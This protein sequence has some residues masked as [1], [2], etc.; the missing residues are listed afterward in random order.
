MN[1]YILLF[2]VSQI[3]VSTYANIFNKIK[4]LVNSK[5]PATEEILAQVNVHLDGIN[6]QIKILSE[7]TSN[8]II[9][10]VK[11]NPLK[12]YLHILPDDIETLNLFTLICAAY[13]YKYKPRVF[14]NRISEPK[15]EFNYRPEMKIGAWDIIKPVLSNRNT[16]AIPVVV[17]LLYI[18]R[19]NFKDY[20]PAYKRYK[21][22]QAIMNH[23]DSIHAIV[24]GKDTAIFNSIINIE[25][26]NNFCA[27]KEISTEMVYLK[28]T[29]SLISKTCSNK[30]FWYSQLI[31]VLKTY[32]AFEKVKEEFDICLKTISHNKCFIN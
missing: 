29:N 16:G 6:S 1:K 11:D 21:A 8:F 23:L 19:K 20:Q 12:G 30:L 2:L 25:A 13:G 22:I 15:P 18:L 9:N 10:K 14:D 5:K 26:L 31:P 7:K 32:T 28:K 3:Y 4:N 27:N 17:W 24:K